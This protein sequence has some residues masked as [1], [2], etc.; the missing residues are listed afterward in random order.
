MLHQIQQ[1]KY[2]TIEDHSWNGSV[3]YLKYMEYFSGGDIS[4]LV[5]L[6]SV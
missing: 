5:L 6:A 1:I 2:K 4:P 3:I